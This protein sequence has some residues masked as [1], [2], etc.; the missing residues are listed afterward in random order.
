L[1]LG[2]PTR[3]LHVNLPL[4]FR[5]TGASKMREALRTDILLTIHR[6][7]RLANLSWKAQRESTQH[8]HERRR[9]CSRGGDLLAPDWG[10][11]VCH[12]LQPSPVTAGALT[13]KRYGETH[14]YLP[15]IF[16]LDAPPLSYA[17]L[18]SERRVPVEIKT[19]PTIWSELTT[20]LQQ[21]VDFE[22]EAPEVP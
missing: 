20:L 7:C 6:S 19:P 12:E 10:A 3:V 13:F 4:G 18:K 1:H 21:A 11:P 15:L 14:D 2:P 16:N 22:A 8:H 5:I 17:I 9:R